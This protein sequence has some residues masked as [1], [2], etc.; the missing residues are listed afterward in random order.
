MRAN[1]PPI[2]K[3]DKENHDYQVINREV[4][5]ALDSCSIE[6]VVKRCQECGTELM[7]LETTGTVPETLEDL[8]DIA[9]EWY[10]E[11]KKEPF[12]PQYSWFIA[13]SKEV[14]EDCL[15]KADVIMRAH[16]LGIEDAQLDTDPDR[17]YEEVTEEILKK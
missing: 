13:I 2:D 1:I 11:V 6:H 17:G 10:I 12:R 14:E 4:K 5:V 9:Y 15:A 7:K 8:L 3:F 16:D